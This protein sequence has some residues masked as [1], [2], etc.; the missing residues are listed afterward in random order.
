MS[1]IE[2]RTEI[3]DS[4]LLITQLVCFTSIGRT[5]NQQHVLMPNKTK[6]L[7]VFTDS[8]GNFDF[9]LKH[10]RREQSSKVSSVI[11]H[12]SSKTNLNELH[13]ATG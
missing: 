2:K 9:I 7:I 3:L 12:F 8:F 4:M 11:S 13:I 1:L 5:Y 6:L 10:S